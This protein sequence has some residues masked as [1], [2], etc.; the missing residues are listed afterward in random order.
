MYDN[1]KFKRRLLSIIYI[2]AETRRIKK[3]QAK[4]RKIMK[5]E[6]VRK[7]KE[8]SRNNFACYNCGRR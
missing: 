7:A 2:Y 6:Y 5:D 4:Q 1:Q 3:N 8:K